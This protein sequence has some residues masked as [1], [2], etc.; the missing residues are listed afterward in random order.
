MRV[1]PLAEAEFATFAAWR[2]GDD[3]YLAGVLGREMAEHR[4]GRRRIFVAVVEGRIVGT[5]Q[6]NLWAED[7]ALAD[8][9][10]VGHLQ[11]LEVQQDHR[12]RGMGRA[13]CAAVE[14]E[15]WAR[16]LRWVTVSV[17]PENAAA[18]RLYAELGYAEFKRSGFEWRGRWIPV[19]CLRKGRSGVGTAPDAGL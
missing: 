8:G 17:E 1:R 5:A 3:A 10:S 6:L 13:L 15:A 4:E 14:A 16:G 2:A 11:A 19:V 12:R 18:R 9:R 7:R